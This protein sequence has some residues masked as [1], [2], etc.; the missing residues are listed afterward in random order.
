M[1]MESVKNL[2]I[3]LLFSSSLDHNLVSQQGLFD[4]FKTG[5]SQNDINNFIAAPGI[6]ALIL[7]AQRRDVIFESNRI[8]LNERTGKMPEESNLIDNLRIIIDKSFF[9]KEK[10]VAYGFNYEIIAI[11]DNESFDISD[12]VSEKIA[13]IGAIKG[14]G[15]SFVFDKNGA[16]YVVEIKPMGG[17][18]KKFSVSLN[19]HHSKKDLPPFDDLKKD[20]VAGFSELKELIVK[21]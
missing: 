7:P 11:P 5:N 12:L 4:S 14:V 2:N 10:I 3:T 1:K 8:L 13:K 21:I 9:E 17:A 15:V 16:R 6:K 19:I 18:M 20:L